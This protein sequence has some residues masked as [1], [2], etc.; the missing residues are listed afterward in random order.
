VLP[1][2]DAL[3]LMNKSAGNL[4]L[5]R[6]SLQEALEAG[7]RDGAC[8]NILAELGV[9]SILPLQALR[10]IKTRIDLENAAT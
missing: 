4:L 5:A 2:Q 6:D 9:T 10:L 8:A 3:R 1:L 7:D